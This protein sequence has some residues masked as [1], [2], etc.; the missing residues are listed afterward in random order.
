MALSPIR[1]IRSMMDSRIQ[2]KLLL[3]RGAVFQ[4][5]QK[6]TLTIV[7]GSFFV[8]AK[9]SR[10][11][12]F[13]SHLWIAAEANMTVVN[14]FSLYTDSRIYVH[15]GAS[16]IIG[17]G[18]ANY[19]LNLECYSSISIGRDVAIAANVSIRDSDNK[20]LFSNQDISHSRVEIG[21]HV[22]IGMNS[23][24]LKGVKI[25]AGAV[26]AAGSV[27]V[28]DVPANTLVGGVPAKFIRS[29]VHWH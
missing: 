4:M 9:W 6:S 5:G 12:P 26:I 1:Q 16:L 3:G 14:N 29:N 8:N 25:G 24:I 21:D 17:G 10:S 18:Y 28:H 13:K 22:W 19:G 23:T 27:V 11:D 20:S 15:V 2:G 7:N